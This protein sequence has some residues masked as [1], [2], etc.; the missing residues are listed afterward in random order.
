MTPTTTWL[1]FVDAVESGRA[2]LLLGETA[3][4]VPV[5][6]LP[7]GAREGSWVRLSTTLAQP[8]SDPE[9]L[10]RQLGKDDPGGP[11]KL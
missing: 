1:V 7:D 6:L 9:L 10:R 4:E 5:P 2:R 8:P 3:F 11:I